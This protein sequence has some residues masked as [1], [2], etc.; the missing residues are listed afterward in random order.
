[1]I[2][3]KNNRFFPPCVFCTAADRNWNWIL[4]Q[5][6]KKLE[7]WG[8]QKVKKFSDWFS[9]LDTILACDSQTDSHLSMA[10]TM[11]ACVAGFKMQCF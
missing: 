3:V 1:V 8:Y 4:A 5:G 6:V 9:D 7:G 2:S 11:L 10:K